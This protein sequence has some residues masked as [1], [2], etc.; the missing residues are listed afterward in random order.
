[1]SVCQL[2]TP[3]RRVDCLLRSAALDG[4]LCSA[5]SQQPTFAQILSV[6]DR[7]AAAA[8]VGDSAVPRPRH[9]PPPPGTENFAPSG[10]RAARRPRQPGG[11]ATDPTLPLFVHSQTNTAATATCR[12]Q[13]TT[14]MAG[15]K[16][17]THRR[18]STAEA[19]DNI[20]V[21]ADCAV[22]YAK[23]S[24]DSAATN[25]GGKSEKSVELD[26]S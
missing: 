3:Q 21:A 10:G 26:T 8:T 14:A 18:R 22:Y 15:R 16:R 19:D 11:R 25:E 4:R 2:T 9:S 1:M 17:L 12:L 7:R 5:P 23:R 6:D 13:T 20:E 24:S